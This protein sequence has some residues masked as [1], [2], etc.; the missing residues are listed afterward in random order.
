MN[1]GSGRPPAR[2]PPS[3]RPSQPSVAD[4]SDDNTSDNDEDTH[5][6]ASA[7]LCELADE[8]F[9]ASFV[10][11]DGRLFH[12]HGRL[13]YP[14][15]ADGREQK[16]LE[17]QNLVLKDVMGSICPDMRLVREVLASGTGRALDLCTGTGQWVKDMA[18]MFPQVKVIGI[19]IVPIQTRY[20]PGRAQFEIA[21]IT[22][23]LRHESN[24]FD[25]VHARCTAFSVTEQRYPIMLRDVA[26]VLRPGGLF[27]SGEFR[28]YPVFPERRPGRNDPDILCPHFF[29][30]LG[31]TAQALGL[32]GVR[33]DLSC[34]I[35]QWL[36]ASGSFYNITR[37]TFELP[38]GDWH[39][40]QRHSGIKAAEIFVGFVEAMESFLGYSGLIPKEELARLMGGAIYELQ[41]VSG[42]V[43]YYDVVC[44][45]KR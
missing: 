6:D 11:R 12:S 35:P 10:T 21:D 40:E 8:D 7:D 26:R 18:V 45:H 39:P 41:H 14:L 31:L 43:M 16:R 36:E 17:A 2:H 3:G 30:F 37:R 28:N 5:S 19:D 32:L 23:G 24:S 22:E 34:K 38:I 44:A 33:W 15:P 20:P 27:I 42:L 13:P 25:L 1:N 9:P 4:P 29:R